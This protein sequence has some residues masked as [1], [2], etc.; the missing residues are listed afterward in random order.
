MESVFVKT[1]QLAFSNLNLRF[2]PFGEIDISARGSLAYVDLDDC[3][4]HLKNTRAAIQFFADH[5]RGKTTH[6]L[7]LHQHFPKA[8]YIKLQQG[9]TPK[10]PKAD[11][12]FIDS[13]EILKKK[14]RKRVF[15]SLNRVVFTSHSDLEAELELAG[16]QVASRKVSCLDVESLQRIFQLR[17]EFARR[18]SGD[19]PIVSKET[20]KSLVARYHDDIRSMEASLYTRLQQ[21]E[22][23]GY[24]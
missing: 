2:N 9:Q 22:N 3:I 24:V 15:R 23:I 21:M 5:G 12:V 14:D 18:A 17:I 1:P 20:V 10:V 13:L 11:L 7:A 8:P 6:L 19:V 16:F 4:E